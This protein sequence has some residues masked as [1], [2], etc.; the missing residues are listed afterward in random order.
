MFRNRKSEIKIVGN[1]F[2]N[3]KTWR[4]EEGTTGIEQ[5]IYSAISSIPGVVKTEIFPNGIKILKHDSV[6]W[7]QIEKPLKKRLEK[8]LAPEFKKSLLC[9]HCK[10]KLNPD[11]KFCPHCGKKRSKKR[12]KGKILPFGCFMRILLLAALGLILFSFFGVYIGSHSL[13][14][15]DHLNLRYEKNHSVAEIDRTVYVKAVFDQEYADICSKEKDYGLFF[16][17]GIHFT[18]Q[19]TAEKRIINVVNRASK[20]FGYQFGVKFVITGIEK[21]NSS[22]ENSLSLIY[23][24]KSEVP[25]DNCDIV[26]GFT[27]RN[28][29][30]T[31]RGYMPDGGHLGNYTLEGFYVPAQMNWISCVFNSYHLQSYTLTHELGHNFGAEHPEEIYSF[32]S[33]QGVKKLGPFLMEVGGY[34][35]NTFSVMSAATGI[36]T[37][38]FDKYNTEI[39]LQNKHLPSK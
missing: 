4:I 28:T 5:E 14:G 13:D 3:I 15:I 1:P 33:F 36:F 27:S 31:C 25:L 16:E 8:C 10:T 30:W 2:Q 7:E 37:T 38:H 12:E 32:P 35:K 24:L 29:D 23:E 26:I 34:L 39:I 20:S 11:N 9:P 22:G 21:W 6:S 19:Q 18:K 17:N